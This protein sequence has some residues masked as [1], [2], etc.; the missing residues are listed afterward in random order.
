MLETPSPITPGGMKGVG[1]AGT[2]G[3]PAAIANAV[4]AALPEIAD[5]I[6]DVPLTPSGLWSLLEVSQAQSWARNA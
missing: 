5:K 2:I 1:E 4:A 3:P 6:T